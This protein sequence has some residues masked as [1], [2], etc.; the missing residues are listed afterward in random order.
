[1]D[2]TQALGYLYSFTNYEALAMSP[3]TDLRLNRMRRLLELA[4]N[5]HQRFRSVLIA[6]TKGKGSTAAM[7]A[8]ISQAAGQ[9]TGLYTSPHLNTHRERYRIDGELI[10][11]DEFARRLMGVRQIVERY[12]AELSPPTTYEL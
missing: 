8:C 12:D 4:G 7:L 9:R 1:M 2:Y 3:R 10:S 5:P 6:G 11:Q